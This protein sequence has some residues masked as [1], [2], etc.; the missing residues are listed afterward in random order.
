MGN[1]TGQRLPPHQ[2]SDPGVGCT[3]LR[4]WLFSSGYFRET[5]RQD[6]RKAR[7]MYSGEQLSRELANIQQRLDNV[8]LLSLDIV[9][10]LLLSYRD[11]QASRPQPAPAGWLGRWVRGAVAGSS[12]GS[13]ALGAPA[14]G[15]WRWRQRWGHCPGVGPGLWLSEEVAGPGSQARACA[16]LA[17]GS[18]SRS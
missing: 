12:E 16:A 4:A 3:Q 2:A 11:V 7:E 15:H 13:V 5:I 18:P 14:Q 9:M 17:R 10:N 6:I 1:C 8:E